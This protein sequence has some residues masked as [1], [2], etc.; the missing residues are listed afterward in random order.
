[1]RTN[2]SVRCLLFHCEWGRKWINNHAS[3]EVKLQSASHSVSFVPY[4]LVLA[5]IF[6]TSPDDP[7]SCSQPYLHAAACST[8]G[9]CSYSIAISTIQLHTFSG[10]TC[11]HVGISDGSMMEHEHPTE[12]EVQSEQQPLSLSRIERTTA[13][14]FVQRRYRRRRCRSRQQ[15]PQNLDGA[16]ACA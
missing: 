7:S 10:G 6:C 2:G 16:S 8:S 3:S 1:M 9:S 15:H 11:D 4:F 12:H 14:L 5:A 13:M